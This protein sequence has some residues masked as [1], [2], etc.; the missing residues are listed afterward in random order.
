MMPARRLPLEVL[1]NVIDSLE[2]DI[3]GYASLRAC[4]LT[5]TDCLPR[6]RLNLYYNVTLRD[7]EALS[8]FVQTLSIRSHLGL[9]V[10]Q[11]CIGSSAHASYLSFAQGV[12]VRSLRN[13]RRLVLWMDWNNC[14]PKYHQIVSQFPIRELH[15]QREFESMARLFQLLW[16]LPDLR[17]VTLGPFVCD[18]LSAI[19]YERLSALATRRFCHNLT[20][21]S[22][23][24]NHSNSAKN[25]PPKH[26]FGESIVRLSLAF[27]RTPSEDDLSVLSSC[28][29]HLH[30]SQARKARHRRYDRH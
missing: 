22:L 10:Q 4:A 1:E 6:S 17:S 9:F 18:S 2:R 20:H 25:F 16:V 29:L 21:L 27:D 8:S 26:A 11:L 13:L 23:S 24:F 28:G 7:K 14:P 15:L 12:L 3:G 19:V 30:F 5:C